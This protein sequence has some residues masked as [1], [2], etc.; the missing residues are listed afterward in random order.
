M[1]TQRDAP[2]VIPS[3]AQSPR[4]RG[5]L[6]FC[7]SRGILPLSP[8]GSIVEAVK[9]IAMA[10]KQIYKQRKQIKVSKNRAWSNLVLVEGVPWPRVGMRSSLRPFQHKPSWDC[11]IP[12]FPL[13]PELRKGLTCLRCAAARSRCRTGCR[14]PAP[15]CPCPSPPAAAWRSIASAGPAKKPSVRPPALG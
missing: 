15:A 7:Y 11:G 1:W 13:I 9:G 4:S 12:P 3:E 14:A 10:E 6:P 8:P 2:C 5:I